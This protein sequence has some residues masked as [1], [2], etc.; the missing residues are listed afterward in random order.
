MSDTRNIDF[1]K[2]QEESQ[3]LEQEN[4][5]LQ[6]RLSAIEASLANANKKSFLLNILSRKKSTSTSFNGDRLIK[7]EKRGVW[8]SLWFRD[9]AVGFNAIRNNLSNRVESIVSIPSKLSF[10]LDEF[11]SVAK[12]DIEQS[13]QN[14]KGFVEKLKISAKVVRSVFNGSE[15][16][17]IDF[18]NENLTKGEFASEV[19]ALNKVA[20]KEFGLS[21]E[22]HYPDLIE[23]TQ[24]QIKQSVIARLVDGGSVEDVSRSVLT[25]ESLIEKRIA[26]FSKLFKGEVGIGTK[27]AKEIDIEGAIVSLNKMYLDDKSNSQNLEAYA[28]IAN[29]SGLKIESVEAILANA[30]KYN[31][32]PFG[33]GEIFDSVELSKFSNEYENLATFAWIKRENDDKRKVVTGELIDYAFSLNDN[34]VFKNSDINAEAKVRKEELSGENRNRLEMCISNR[35][36]EDFNTGLFVS[37][38][39]NYKKSE[40]TTSN[41]KEVLL[42][43]Y[44]YFYNEKIENLDQINRKNEMGV[45]GEFYSTLK[46]NLEASS[47]YNQRSMVVSNIVRQLKDEIESSYDLSKLESNSSKIIS[48][49]EALDKIAFEIHSATKSSKDEMEVVN[50]VANKVALASGLSLEKNTVVELILSGVKN[51]NVDELFGENGLVT[52]TLQGENKQLAE[53]VRINANEYANRILLSRDIQSLEFNVVRDVAL[54]FVDT[55]K[56]EVE[57]QD[58][59]VNLKSRVFN[60]ANRDITINAL[61]KFSKHLID[62]DIGITALDDMEMKLLKAT[63]DVKE[64][65]EKLVL[66]NKENEVKSVEDK[67]NDLNLKIDEVE[68]STVDEYDIVKLDDNF[69]ETLNSYLYP[70]STPE[71]RLG[72]V[73]TIARQLNSV[74]SD[75]YDLN[76]VGSNSEKIALSNEALDKL[77]SGIYS[78]AKSSKEKMDIINADVDKIVSASGQNLDRNTVV[79]L[80]L[81]GVKNDNI[82]ELFGQNGLVTN[83]LQGENKQLAEDIRKNA[84][85]Y[86]NRI[87]L[88]RDIQSLGFSV[89]RDVVLPFVDNAKSKID[90]QG[91]E[92]NLKSRVFNLMDRDITVDALN[93]FAKHIVDQENAITAF[94]D[95]EMKFLKSNYENKKGANKWIE[96]AK[97]Q[98][99]LGKFKSVVNQYPVN[100]VKEDKQMESFRKALQNVSLDLDEV[101]VAAVEVKNNVGVEYIIPS[102]DDFKASVSQNYI[103]FENS[104]SY[105]AL[106]SIAAPT[107]NSPLIIANV[108][109]KAI[110][111][112][113]G[114]VSAYLLRGRGVSEVDLA[115]IVEDWKMFKSSLNE[116]KDIIS[117]NNIENFDL[118]DS[119]INESKAANSSGEFSKYVN[120]LHDHLSSSGMVEQTDRAINVITDLARKNDANA[121]LSSIFYNTSSLSSEN[122]YEEK[123]RLSR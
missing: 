23:G 58:D 72:V 61:D 41:D 14:V 121:I 107:G 108:L 5:R 92:I 12:N 100:A 83:T 66:N 76:T 51:G 68:S 103:S 73:S 74:L 59:E 35:L 53:E 90:L 122:K 24:N 17:T 57:L 82:D 20:K 21:K 19:N 70:S 22:V 1:K 44:N 34:V 31:V 38:L 120:K 25:G 6:E 89:V 2:M 32:N 96:Q 104:S 105:K 91:D 37:L 52:N 65:A 86:A 49:N 13:Y 4:R 40:V 110:D 98:D 87:L 55:I 39:K 77:S 81:S 95:M 48:S 112:N 113:M 116:V 78:A 64:R 43:M 114:E 3:I 46:S 75:G 109:E 16:V 54:P 45:Q 56:K 94:D 84:S 80:I 123:R 85:E 27:N 10:G 106:V 97:S 50:A 101:P 93:K 62:K 7:G 71:E 42:N 99:L 18:K 88:S 11:K 117:K 33:K 47:T 69:Y 119:Y 29:L 15:S 111:D 79:E 118:T 30:Y 102:L 115:K 8:R 9:D 26:E 63:Y 67:I 28:E 60:I 36:E